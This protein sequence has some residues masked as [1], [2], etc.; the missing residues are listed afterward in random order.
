MKR[1]DSVRAVR[2]VLRYELLHQ[3]DHA[4]RSAG[5]LP[6]ES[7]LALDHA[8]SRNVIR[9]ALLALQQEGIVE[10]VQG[11]GTFGLTAKARQNQSRL[12][13]LA[14][15]LGSRGHLVAHE[16]QLVELRPA[17]TAVA[18]ALDL[19]AGE[20]VLVVER[21]GSFDGTP[22]CLSTRYLPGR[23]APRLLALDLTTPDWYAAIEAA[24]GMPVSGARLLTE[25]TLADDLLAPELGV[26]VGS[27]VMLLQRTV[28]TVDDR[29]VELSFT[30]VR[31]DLYEIETWLE[32]H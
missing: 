27:P 11:A 8:T 10:R 5:A 4:S 28:F 1:R 17:P 9:L 22:Y 12:A 32:R 20:E 6:S 15:G 3:G 14:T 19:L 21:K 13:G 2:D 16:P 7:E 25:A 23:L 26:T 31:G 30:R 18:A 24:A 29:P